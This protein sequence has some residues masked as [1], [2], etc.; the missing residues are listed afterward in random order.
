MKKYTSL[1]KYTYFV[2]LQNIRKNQGIHTEL[3]TYEHEHVISD[4]NCLNFL[5]TFF[6]S[7]HF[8][9]FHNFFLKDH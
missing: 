3:Y 2:F 7:R 4:F 6:T 1:G 8:F 5:S 9:I